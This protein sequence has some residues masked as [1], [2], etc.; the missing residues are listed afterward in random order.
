MPFPATTSHDVFLRA[1]LTLQVGD[2]D[3]PVAVEEVLR[4]MPPQDEDIH[5]TEPLSKAVLRDIQFLERHRLLTFDDS[6]P[7]VKMT[8]LGVYTALMFEPLS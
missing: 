2:F 1:L 4:A 3:K 7:H 6:N 8:S 5:P